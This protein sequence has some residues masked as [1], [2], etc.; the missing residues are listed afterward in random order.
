MGEDWWVGG[1]KNKLFGVAMMSVGAIHNKSRQDHWA[2]QMSQ[3]H[4]G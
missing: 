4:L 2:E 3:W 1:G